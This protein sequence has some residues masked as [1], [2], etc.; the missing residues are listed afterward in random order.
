MAGCVGRD[1]FAAT[2][3]A[4]LRDAGIDARHVEPVDSPTGTALITIDGTGANTIVVISGA[5]MA[6]DAALVDRALAD[7][8]GPGHP[9]A[10]ARNPGR[11]RTPEPYSLRGQPV[12]SSP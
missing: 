9:A 11:R 5:N 1:A 8:G 6:V 4:G 12:G 3:M 7:A 2:L 10:A